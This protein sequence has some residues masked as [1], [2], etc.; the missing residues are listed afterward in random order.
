[1]I[2][3]AWRSALAVVLFVGAGYGGVVGCKKSDPNGP[4][5]WEKQLE[6]EKTRR[7]ALVKIADDLKEPAQKEWA[8]KLVVKH[9][10]KDP[11]S[12]AT[13][14]G[15]LGVASGEVIDALE[16]AIRS[17][18][19]GVMPAAAIAIR[20]LNG[21]KAEGALS[22]ILTSW[23]VTNP[24]QM[25]DV[26]VEVIRALGQ[27]ETRAGVPAMVAVANAESATK[28]ERYEALAALSKIGDARALPAFIQGLYLACAMDRCSAVS[29]I[30][31]ARIGKASI[32]ALL[33]VLAGKNADVQKLAK[34]RKLDESQGQ[35]SAVPLIALGDVADAATAKQL[36]AKYLDGEPTMTKASAI[37]AIGYAGSPAVA[38]QL[39]TYYEK[40]TL[41]T[42]TNILHALHRIGATSAVP[43]LT[44]IIEKNED[45][46][47]VWN[48]GLALSY[49][50]GEESIA[51]AERT[52]KK[53][54]AGMKGKG[55]EAALA[56]Q[57]AAF[58]TQFVA[59]LRAAK[60]CK[61]DAC[62]IG[63]LKDPN[64]E[65]RIK[66][67]RMLAFAKDR[68]AAEAALI[69]SLGDPV[70]DV[71]E[72]IAFALGKVGTAE[73]VVPA[74]KARLADD[75]KSGG[76]KASTFLYELLAARLQGRSA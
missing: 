48:A 6:K 18:D 32:P 36:A 22:E 42:R 40:P 43:F 70:G 3:F 49:L 25:R 39:K 7:V 30:G 16:K 24:Q 53:A 34:A 69:G 75:K 44:E 11:S 74:V 58:Y 37:A 60:G 47:L 8:A 55:E 28:A 41:E 57:T 38:G 31:L 76:M 66:A 9:F 50:G 20:K 2:R 56:K 14:L 68:V 15:K 67:V 1:M 64:K 35:V 4:A 23:S 62:W 12:S 17:K 21:K 10:D 59:R 26:R 51:V 45:P 54:E 73:K 27:F 72:E 63:K 65:V 52:L 13:A 33:D 19:P 29:R 71:R 5:Y 61:N 46:N